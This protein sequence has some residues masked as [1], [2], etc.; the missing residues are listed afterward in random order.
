MKTSKI[1]TKMRRRK[2]KSLSKMKLNSK[3]KSK[4][5]KIPD[6]KLLKKCQST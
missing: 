2:K 1:R 6:S 4:Q 5:L 3:I